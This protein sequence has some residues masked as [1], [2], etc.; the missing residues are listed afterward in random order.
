MENFNEIKAIWQQQ[1]QELPP[2]KEVLQKIKKYKRTAIVKA[3]VVLL[4]LVLSLIIMLLVLVNTPFKLW[5]SYVGAILVCITIIYMFLF[6]YNTLTKKRNE[7]LMSNNAYLKKLKQ[8]I[9]DGDKN[10]YKTKLF[11]MCIWGVA[12]A[13]FIYEIVYTSTQY[14][15]IGYAVLI[16]FWVVL[17]FVYRPYKVK[18]YQEKIQRFIQK[19]EAIH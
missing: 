2:V 11:G 10:S 9:V 19:I 12:Y 3:Y 7:G 4:A 16:I 15:V 6:K 5:T 18:K 8:D 14:M 1:Q 13:F 17:W